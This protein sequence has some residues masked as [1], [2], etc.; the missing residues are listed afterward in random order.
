MALALDGGGGGW[1]WQSSAT[2]TFRSLS[3][4]CRFDLLSAS[5]ESWVG[6]GKRSHPHTRVEVGVAEQSL[7]Q[8]FRLCAAGDAVNEPVQNVQ[9]LGLRR[10]VSSQRAA[11]GATRKS[12]YEV[13]RDLAVAC[14]GDELKGGRHLGRWF[15]L[16]EGA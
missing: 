14:F 11:N 4:T 16:G 6:K 3:R 5:L 9:H 1:P 15:V 8:R 2:L 13:A 12:T 10:C 7:G